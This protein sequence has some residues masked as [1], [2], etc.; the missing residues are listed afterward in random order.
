MQHCCL[1]YTAEERQAPSSVK[2]AS[3]IAV[4]LNQGGTHCRGEVRGGAKMS[5]MQQEMALH[6][7]EQTLE[8]GHHSAASGASSSHVQGEEG[9]TVE[10]QP[11]AV[12][13]GG[14]HPVDLVRVSE[15]GC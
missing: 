8:R 15:H 1:S 9:R 10:W 11:H 13:S 5:Q 2:Q 12:L 7:Y 14:E 3:N 6:R 4:S